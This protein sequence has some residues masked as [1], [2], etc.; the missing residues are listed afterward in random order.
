M[1]TDDAGSERSAPSSDEDWKDRVKSE[2]AAL[3]QKLKGDTPATESEPMGGASLEDDAPFPPPTF[4]TLV[5]MFTTQ[6]MVAMGLIANPATGK[7]D[8]QLRLA[9]HFIDMLAVLEEKTRRNLTGNE[10]TLLETSLHQL[11]MAY[12][13]VSQR[14]RNAP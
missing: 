12:I 9:Q 5:S 10:A 13:E 11:R 8:P 14:L 7:A 2:D 4:S 6:A 3:D 1:S